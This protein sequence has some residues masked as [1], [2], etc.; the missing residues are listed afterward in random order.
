MKLL[1]APHNDDEILFAG[2][3]SMIHHPLVLIVFDS[4]VQLSRG[5]FGCSRDAR[6]ME[7]LKAAG[8]LEAGFVEFCGLRDDVDYAAEGRTSDIDTAIMATVDYATDAGNRITDVYAPLWEDYGHEQHNLVAA[9]AAFCFSS[10]VKIHRYTT[11]TRRGGR[12]RTENIVPAS[13]EM[14][15]KKHQALACFKSQMQEVTGCREWFMGG[16]EEY[17]A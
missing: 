6:R 5:Y 14:I 10:N 17:L 3:I 1:L 13:P 8:I 16:L 11:Y 15:A 12:T 7:S 4:Y 2:F 9:S